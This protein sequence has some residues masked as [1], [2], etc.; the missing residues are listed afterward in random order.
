M[1]IDYDSPLPSG[2]RPVGRKQSRKGQ[3]T[4][5]EAIAILQSLGFTVNVPTVEADIKRQ[6][7]SRAALG[8]VEG[9][10]P[11]M[12]SSV[13]ILKGRL[14]AAHIVGGNTY[15]PGEL[16]LPANQTDLYHS[17]LQADQACIRGHM[18]TTQHS[19]V[20]RCYI[21]RPGGGQDRHNKYSKV[22]VSE[23]TFNSASFLDNATITAGA[24]DVA[25]YNPSHGQEQRPF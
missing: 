15:G 11:K 25:G 1:A 23:S 19:T 8:F 3:P 20:S 2:K 10:Q 18:D 12:P 14:Y 4:L 9:E 16:T 13:F 6:E 21:I 22:E 7:A 24:V 17:L 5:E